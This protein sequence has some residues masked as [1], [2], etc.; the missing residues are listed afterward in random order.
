MPPRLVVQEEAPGNGLF[1]AQFVG[2]S[3]T[4][5]L[6]LLGVLLMVLSIGPDGCP[7][8]GY[9]WLKVFDWCVGLLDLASGNYGFYCRSEPLFWTP[10]NWS[11]I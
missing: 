5:W 10:A 6:L 11:E 2:G 9:F 4:F 8:S 7:Y 1:L 3:S